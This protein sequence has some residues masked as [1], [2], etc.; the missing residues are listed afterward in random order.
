[1]EI[2]ENNLLNDVMSAEQSKPELDDVDA[3]IQQL[4]A[5][6]QGCHVLTQNEEQP[7]IRPPT[8]GCSLGT[9]FTCSCPSEPPPGSY[10]RLSNQKE[11]RDKNM[12]A[13]GVPRLTGEAHHT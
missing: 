5:R 10:K 1:M 13:N 3:L 12:G 11:K 9:C 6:F 2:L 7:P 8:N 4:E